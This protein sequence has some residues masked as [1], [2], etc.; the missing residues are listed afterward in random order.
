MNQTAVLKCRF[1]PHQTILEAMRSFWKS[2]LIF[3]MKILTAFLTISLI[4]NLLTAFII[5]GPIVTPFDYLGDP[6][7][8]LAPYLTLHFQLA[9]ATVMGTFSGAILG[10]EIT[11]LLTP[12]WKPLAKLRVLG[13]GALLGAGIGAFLLPFPIRWNIWLFCQQHEMIG[14]F[15]LGVSYYID[16]SYFIWLTPVLMLALLQ[17][18]S[19]KS[20]STTCMTYRFGCRN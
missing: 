9:P 7:Q 15:F 1:I 13:L 4:Y 14:A 10:I 3:I 2:S 12:P 20:K 16:M 8:L 19:T 6:Y 17:G 18:I 11:M 5:P